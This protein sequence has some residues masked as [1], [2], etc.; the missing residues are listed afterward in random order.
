MQ[1]LFNSMRF[2]PGVDASKA[3]DGYHLALRGFPADAIAEGIGKFLRGECEGINPKYCPHPPELAQIVRSAVVPAR[4]LPKLPRPEHHWQAGERERMRLKFP[5]WA[6]AF[7]AGLM[8]E[9]D[10]ANRAGFGAMVVLA[11]KWRVPI[12]PEL[13]EDE[14]RTGR[15]WHLAGNRA[16]AALAGNPPPF[17]RRWRE[18]MG[19]DYA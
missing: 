10:A 4:I 17:M 14:E 7:S 16:R 8:D 1:I 11:H 15:D 3:I 6:Y 2:P 19:R 13:L 18:I 9:L 12:P 5:M